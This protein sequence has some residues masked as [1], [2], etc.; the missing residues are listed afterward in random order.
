MKVITKDMLVKSAKEK[1]KLQYFYMGKWKNYHLV[2]SRLIYTKLS[3]AKTAE[4]VENIIGN[5]SWSFPYCDNCHKY[6]EVVIDFEVLEN[7]IAL[8]KNCLVSAVNMLM[9]EGE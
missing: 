6:V 5:K 3:K 7:N 8:C 9:S 2:D 1:W 4:E